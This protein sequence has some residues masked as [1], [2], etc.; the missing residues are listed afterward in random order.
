MALAPVSAAPR[1]ATSREAK[2][3][4]C[5][6]SLCSRD[7][8]GQRKEAAGVQ[9]ELGLET[10]P[11]GQPEVLP[12]PEVRKLEGPLR[13]AGLSGS[14]PTSPHHLVLSWSR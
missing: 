8:S 2:D 6:L 4:R 5:S 13:K 3:Q 9:D 1:K 7:G 11:G 10:L 14:K 12:S